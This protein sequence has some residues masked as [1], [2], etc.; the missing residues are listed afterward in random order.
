MRAI[1][2]TALLPLLLTHAAHAEDD[3]VLAAYGCF[4]WSEQAPHTF[5][6]PWV[7]DL[8]LRKDFPEREPVCGWYDDTQ[9]RFDEHMKLLDQSGLDVIVI[10]W[11]DDG[12]TEEEDGWINNGTRFFMASKVETNVKFCLSLINHDPFSLKTEADWDRCLAQFL[13]AFRHP[14]YWKV[15]GKPVLTVHS[16]WHMERDDSGVEGT[17]RRVAWLREQVK[18]AGFPG[19][20]FGGGANKCGERAWWDRNL[21]QE[22]FD[23]MTYYNRIGWE[24]MQ[25]QLSKDK[26]TILPYADLIRENT[27]LWECFKAQT[28]VPLAPCMTVQWDPRPWWGSSL[29]HSLGYETPTEAELRDF[30]SKARDLIESDPHYRIPTAD[31]TG[32]KVLFLCAW[33]ELSEGSYLAPTKGA[34]DRRMAAIREA[35]GR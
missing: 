35:F 7:S 14:R 11:Y 28:D 6:K 4:I 26:K 25:D 18:A 13:E 21:K 30:A 15:D 16:T 17:A 20:I 29:P 22:G 3:F 32:K 12:L 8:D 1:L 34:G 31:G 33:N 24:A 10:D 5:S 19:L 23:F 9:A 27:A 2:S